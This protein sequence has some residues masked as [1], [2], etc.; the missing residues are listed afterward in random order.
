MCMLSKNP[1]IALINSDNTFISISV[2]NM[3]SFLFSDD[4][5]QENKSKT[6]LSLCLTT[7]KRTRISK[8]GSAKLTQSLVS[9]NR[10]AKVC[11]LSQTPEGAV[12]RGK[13]RTGVRITY[14]MK[15]R[16][17]KTDLDR[18]ERFNRRNEH[19]VN[20]TRKRT[21]RQQGNMNKRRKGN[22]NMISNHIQQENES[23]SNGDLG[24][25]GTCVI[26]VT[27]KVPK[28]DRVDLNVSNSD[29]TC[30]LKTEAKSEHC[31]DLSIL[32]NNSSTLVGH[33]VVEKDDTAPER[34]LSVDCR[35][36]SID[37]S[38]SSSSAIVETTTCVSS[39]PSSVLLSMPESSGC[40]PSELSGA[41][42]ITTCKFAN[43]TPNVICNGADNTGRNGIIL[44]LAGSNIFI[45]HNVGGGDLGNLRFA[46][47]PLSNGD[48]T[49]LPIQQFTATATVP[50]SKEQPSH[51]LN[52]SSQTLI[53]SASK[54]S[55][56]INNS[57]FTTSSNNTA[58]SIRCSTPVDDMCVPTKKEVLI[59][60]K[61]NSNLQNLNGLSDGLNNSGNVDQHNNKEC[62]VEVPLV[63]SGK[64]NG[65]PVIN[66][67]PISL[68]ATQNNL[69]T[70]KLGFESQIHCSRITNNPLKV[71]AVEVSSDTTLSSS[72]HGPQKG[73]D[74]CKFTISNNTPNLEQTATSEYQISNP[75]SDQI[76]T[77]NISRGMKS[78]HTNAESTSN[79]SQQFV[80]S[81]SHVGKNLLLD[82]DEESSCQL[83]ATAVQTNI[84]PTLELVRKLK[85]L[86]P[87]QLTNL[88]NKLTSQ[89][90]PEIESEITSNPQE[91]NE[92]LTMGIQKAQSTKW[93][94]SPVKS[95][96]SDHVCPVC[97]ERFKSKRTFNSHIVI[98]CQVST[99]VK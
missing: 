43:A 86:Q 62:T 71:D 45:P 28:E 22:N 16:T 46:L 80:H 1:A 19:V 81:G 44:S 52:N 53:N 68:A 47:V 76:N 7:G 36:P 48:Q 96:S 73:A 20:N 84:N 31:N 9:K 21:R 63:V 5:S 15:T 74:K 39:E 30:D 58:R 12:D 11:P 51:P 18:R 98:H 34:T 8:R 59:A 67:Y 49:M 10:V 69:T 50:V 90:V 57:S 24:E 85:L 35:N 91:I 83:N 27:E 65:V 2:A 3:I 33:Y 88:Q 55:L 13:R 97:Q 32:T 92:S 82:T 94:A 64:A 66:A 87:E 42:T 75:N 25:K 17:N 93:G 41:S 60:P 61:L 6:K 70:S 38:S 72:Y 14:S 4:S 26:S 29:L 99:D 89:E 79:I 54:T 77:Y 37:V 40:A 78:S 56:N 95:N 23:I